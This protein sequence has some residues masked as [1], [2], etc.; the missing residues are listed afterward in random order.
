MTL[1][2]SCTPFDIRAL[3]LAAAASPVLRASKR[4]YGQQPDGNPVYAGYED[5]R[6]GIPRFF[7]QHENLTALKESVPGCDLCATIWRQYSANAV[8]QEL[9]EEELRR[10]LGAERV[11]M[12]TMGWDGQ[13][14][15]LP[16]VGAFQ[17]GSRGENRMLASFEVCAVRGNEPQDN[18]HLLARSIYD[19]SGSEE[20][21]GLARDWLHNCVQRH[22]GCRPSSLILPTLPTR[23]I[24]VLNVGDANPTVTLVDGEGRREGFAALSYCWGPDRD[25]IL[26]K[27]TEASLR[28]GLELDK[29]PLTLRHAIVA[30]HKLRLRYIWI[31]AICIQ[32]D[33]AEDW[34][35]EAAKMRNVYK[36]SVVTIAAASASR[37]SEGM[38]RPRASTSYCYLPWLNGEDPPR[39]VFLRPPSEIWDA[40]LNSSILN[41]RAWCLQE[42]L[43]APRTLWFGQQQISFECSQGNIDEAGRSTKSTEA[44]RSKI[45]MQAM[46]KDKLALLYKAYRLIGIPPVVRVPSL[47]FKNLSLDQS[48]RG[49]LKGMLMYSSYWFQGLL[50]TASGMGLTYYDQWREIVGHYC[51]R[52][53]TVASDVLPAL[54][55]LADDFS[56]LTGDAY[57]A[58]LWK[59]DIIRGLNWNRNPTSRKKHERRKTLEEYIAPSWSWA[60]ITGRSVTFGGRSEKHYI[61]C[62]AGVVDIKTEPSTEDPYG[63]LKSGFIILRG[64]FLELDVSDPCDLKDPSFPALSDYISTL[65]VSTNSEAGAEYVQQHEGHEGQRFGLLHLCSMRNV[66]P[67]EFTDAS[68]LLLESCPNGDWKRVSMFGVRTDL[69]KAFLD[70]REKVFMKE[71][72][73]LKWKRKTIKII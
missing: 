21:L 16:L 36:G 23:V 11:W 57:Y 42:C 25:L 68:L 22:K 35:R 53:I 41:T 10:G 59:S 24:D 14:H 72:D 45:H 17:Y 49:N 48:L 65:L 46:S 47:T 4:K 71:F 52:N 13:L 32:Q 73:G 8:P 12:G 20:C 54:S 9:E 2:S 37:A 50:E 27:D 67:P 31:D 18:G 29:F 64:P 30:A 26:T 5:F 38:F 62:S 3:L 15:A 69:D 60:S 7:A 39:K 58:G 28:A 40:T 43:L 19:S 61:I 63:K 51:A 55:G 34:A 33:S 6:H 1:C 56:R 44:Y 70:E 66:T